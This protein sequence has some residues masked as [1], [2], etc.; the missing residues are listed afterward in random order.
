MSLK[1]QI[2]LAYGTRLG[3]IPLKRA[4]DMETELE[5]GKIVLAIS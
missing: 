2:R 5:N 1:F 3:T 4:M